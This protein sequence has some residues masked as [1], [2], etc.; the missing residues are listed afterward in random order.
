MSGVLIFYS[1][2]ED[3]GRRGFSFWFKE[4]NT[5]KHTQSVKQHCGDTPADRDGPFS[6]RLEIMGF[7]NV[8]RE[9]SIAKNLQR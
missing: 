4:G 1:L 2:T 7:E 6:K 9:I 3:A 5:Q 8:Q